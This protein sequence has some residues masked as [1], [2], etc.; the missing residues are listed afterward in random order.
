MSYQSDLTLTDGDGI[1]VTGSNNCI[2]SCNVGAV[3]LLVQQNGDCPVGVACLVCIL[4]GADGYILACDG[5][6]NVVNGPGVTIGNA[7]G[8]VAVFAFN[9]GV[10][11][12]LVFCGLVVAALRSGSGT[13]DLNFAKEVPAVRNS[14]H[15]NVTSRNVESDGDLVSSIVCKS[16][17]LFGLEL[18]GACQLV[19]LAVV[20][21]V[22]LYGVSGLNAGCLVL[23]V[24][25]IEGIQIANCAQIKVHISVAALSLSGS[26]LVER[27]KAG[28]RVAG[29]GKQTVGQLVV[30]IGVGGGEGFVVAPGNVAHTELLGN[31]VGLACNQVG[32]LSGNEHN[33]AERSNQCNNKKSCKSLFHVCFSFMDF[34]LSI[35]Y[36]YFSDL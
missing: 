29:L 7:A 31:G 11:P 35:Y 8:V 1:S 21:N 2:L 33:A 9:Q 14:S 4:R 19:V 24:N 15:L 5:A 26:L 18:L 16:I 6:V 22:D 27:H 12:G 20:G 28:L 34:W 13:K 23:Q 3:F 17:E 25:V 30:V 32:S 36:Y 10:F